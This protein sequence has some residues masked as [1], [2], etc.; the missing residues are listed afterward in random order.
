MDIYHKAILPKMTK[1]F[2]IY[3]FRVPITYIENLEANCPTHLIGWARIVRYSEA[4]R[5]VGFILKVD[6]L[7]KLPPKTSK[8]SMRNEVGELEQW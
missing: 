3:N 1:E 5:N 2:T 8:Q 4:E 6:F 7:Q